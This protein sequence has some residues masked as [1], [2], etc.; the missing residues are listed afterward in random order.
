MLQNFVSI[1]DTS[2]IYKIGG[3]GVTISLIETMLTQA[4][5]KDIV[6]AI[7]TGV[8]LSAIIAV[9][10]IISEVAAAIQQMTNIMH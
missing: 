4:G 9:A 5:R 10:N 1:F 3:F 2:I 7:N 8:G 6:D